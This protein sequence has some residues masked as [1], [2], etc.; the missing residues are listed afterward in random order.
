M[1]TTPQNKKEELIK[2]VKRWVDLDT[3]IKNTND[4]IKLFRE[5]KIKITN[6]ILSNISENS[7]KLTRIQLPDGELQFYTKKDYSP[8]TFKFL[9]KCLSEIISDESQTAYII[10]YVKNKRQITNGID[11]KRIYGK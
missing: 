1:E 8:L 7:P 9:E 10:E 6:N 5:E 3:Q 4:K 2:N 11:I